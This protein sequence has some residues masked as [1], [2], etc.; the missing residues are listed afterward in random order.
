MMEKWQFLIQK[1]GDRNWQPLESLYVDILEGR[2]RVV[3]RSSRAN[4]DVEVRVTHVS[5]A[6]IPPKRRIHKRLRRTDDEGLMAVI[7]FTYFAPGA[8]EVRCSGDLMSDVL[9]TSWQHT[10]K[11]QVLHQGISDDK[12]LPVHP[13]E[14]SPKIN[15]TAGYTDSSLTE[16]EN[17]SPTIQ[18]STASNF[19]IP[20]IPPNFAD[21]HNIPNTNPST[22]LEIAPPIENRISTPIEQS[23]QPSII[24]IA[25]EVCETF[26]DDAE[27][28]TIPV[29]KIQN[30][31]I[32]DIHDIDIDID[33]DIDG[34]IRD[35][36]LHLENTEIAA[37]IEEQNYQAEQLPQ[38]VL[39][40]LS[41]SEFG[42]ETPISSN[43][44][45]TETTG[46]IAEVI[47]N[48]LP[49]VSTDNFIESE[50]IILNRS[51]IQEESRQS[52][53]E[54]M[55]DDSRDIDINEPVVL[56]ISKFTEKTPSKAL[57]E[58]IVDL[59]VSPVWV[60]GDT[61]E[62]ILH[63]LIE[64]A[65]PATEPLLPE[66][67]VEKSPKNDSQQPLSLVLDEHTYIARWGGTLTIYGRVQLKEATG[68]T[69]VDDAAEFESVA[70]GELRLE[71]RSPFGR[72]PASPFE[73]SR[74][75]FVGESSEGLEV[76]MQV[77]QALPEK[78]LPFGFDFSI[79]IPVNCP[80]KLLLAD[81][82]L[83]GVLGGVGD[84]ELLA[85]ESFTIT[86]DVTELL[87]V[88][89]TVKPSAPDMLDDYGLA[90]MTPE[91]EP[92][93]SLD[94]ELFN[95]VKSSKNQNRQ[96]LVLQASPKRA[97]PLQI[98]SR[99]LQ[100]SSRQNYSLGA[101]SQ[102]NNLESET[103]G[104][105]GGNAETSKTSSS[106]PFLR[107]RTVQQSINTIESIK[108]IANNT[109][110]NPTE[111]ISKDLENIEN[112]VDFLPQSPNNVFPVE[113]NQELH[114]ELN[115]ELNQEQVNQ[116]IASDLQT[117][118]QVNE[119]NDLFAADNPQ[120]RE[121]PPHDQKQS[122]SKLVY[123]PPS[124]GNIPANR[125]YISPLI[126]KWMQS[127]GY[128]VLETLDLSYQNSDTN[129]PVVHNVPPVNTLE[130]TSDYPEYP[131]QELLNEENSD[132]LN[133]GLF[134]SG[135]NSELVSEAV[136]ESNP[137][138]SVSGLTDSRLTEQQ[139][140]KNTATPQSWLAR[141][142][143]VD[144]VVDDIVS[145]NENEN[146]TNSRQ[147]QPEEQPISSVAEILS[148]LGLDVEEEI[149][150]LPVPQLSLPT[151]ELISGNTIRVR[152][153]VPE[154]RPQTAV[155]LWLEDCQTRWLLEGPHILT[156]LLPNPF[157]EGMEAIAEINIPFGC[158]ELRIEAIAIDIVTQQESHKAS[159]QRTVIP[160][161]LPILHMDELL[162][163]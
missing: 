138:T 4:T 52:T 9:G 46:V 54:E 93:V 88:K 5:P 133:S 159:I 70:R 29:E 15:D 157:G 115:Q 27:N 144:D 80:S 149:E 111:S 26:V 65:L 83:Y 150:L 61:A 66:E 59:P 41:I 28:P 125:P 56:N 78:L 89:A 109:A 21:T 25:A 13:P 60:K 119:G 7:P 6:E 68:R 39:Q 53:S 101:S 2:Y 85:S 97:L 163:I 141:E 162:G 40:P 92:P 148:S 35:A 124:S 22:K 38:E 64:L 127:Q 136:S 135:L 34:I 116:I 81:V 58:I 110:V 91:L 155:K 130:T 154:I 36:D 107:R 106:L 137:E 98:E 45:S 75:G 143:V 108:E 152:V 37:E 118:N 8:W 47:E 24:D 49:A 76:L 86:A 147:K 104:V 69:L 134:K 14:K 121:N 82:S 90:Q 31:S 73:R 160:P 128:S 17:V 112:Y 84:L 57:E 44:V 33:I 20:P 103:I 11:L 114:Q 140:F 71:L 51:T 55:G 43:R 126:N 3:A 67:K 23:Q 79:E 151:G 62:Q 122:P 113:A 95:L 10:L 63:N 16:V 48:Q 142:I 153:V 105:V 100:H 30:H 132:S 12:P 87:A 32:P 74:S 161:D 50:N 139:S 129:I 145:D 102:F 146:I 18:V 117:H 123:S 120:T 96:P 1:Q 156:D 131:N 99:K 19:P 158:L 77:Q 94:L 42:E 72:L